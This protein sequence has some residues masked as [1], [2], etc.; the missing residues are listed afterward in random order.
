MMLLFA[1]RTLHDIF[2]DYI[3]N[4]QLKMAVVGWQHHGIYYSS[5]K[6]NTR[7]L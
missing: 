4:G 7:R 5:R 1:L 6:K 3:S 2:S